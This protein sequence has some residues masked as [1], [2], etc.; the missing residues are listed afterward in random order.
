MNILF[1]G[2]I[3]S[4]GDKDNISQNSKGSMQ[5]AADTL[6][7]N[8]ITGFSQ[9]DSV[10]AISVISLP[11]IGAY[12]KRYKNLFYRPVTVRESLG[13][14]TVLNVGFFN[15]TIFK[16]LHKTILAIKSILAEMKVNPSQPHFLVCYSMHLPFL[17]AC[18]VVKRVKRDTHLCIIVPDLPEYMAVRKGL[19]KFIFH[20]LS[21]M[22][23]SIVNR[24][25]SIVAIT[26]EMLNKFDEGIKKIVIEGIADN[27]Y[28]SIPEVVQRKKYFLYTGTLDRRYGIRNLLDSYIGSGVDD[29]ELFI[30]GDGDDRKYVEGVVATGAKVK[31][32]GQLDRDSVLTLQRNAALLINPRDNNS[33]FTKYSF[34][35]KIIEYMSSGVPVL[36]YRLDGIPEDYY[37]FCYLIPRGDDGLKIKLLELSKL[38]DNQFISKGESAKKFIVENKMPDMQVAKLLDIF[39]GND[40]V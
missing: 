10:N 37:D 39:K 36:M 1:L 12:P 4:E 20:L 25:D 6:Q 34:P 9:N 15:L 11:F 35:S 21:L 38:S 19:A 7:K 2:G 26:R 29:Y 17:L 30:C 24:A 18:Y 32:F 40:H 3:F 23:Y 16:N 31:Y 33:E 8:Y 14:A 28:I 13:C 27:R 5:Y 22:S